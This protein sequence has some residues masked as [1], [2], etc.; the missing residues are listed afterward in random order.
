MSRIRRENEPLP[1]LAHD[2]RRLVRYANPGVPLGI[3]E[4]MAKDCFLDA[5]IDRELELAVFQSQPKIR[6]D[7]IK[8]P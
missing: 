6:Q 4:N 7:A 2:I 5:L 8:H 3:Q 1:Q